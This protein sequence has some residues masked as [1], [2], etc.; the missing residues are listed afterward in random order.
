MPNSARSY[1]ITNHVPHPGACISPPRS[2]LGFDRLIENLSS[3]LFSAGAR[4]IEALMPV[5][6]MRLIV[7][8]Q[9]MNWAFFSLGNAV[10]RGA[11]VSIQGKLIEIETGEDDA[12]RGCALLSVRVVD[13]ADATRGVRNTLSAVR[14]TVEQQSGLVRYWKKDGEMRFSFYLPVLH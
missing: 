14:D 4:K 1:A 10:A 13:G 12:N 9:A 5:R 3:I 8:E 2:T 7:Q 6:P 11:T